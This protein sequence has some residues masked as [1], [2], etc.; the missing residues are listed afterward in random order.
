MSE[1]HQQ[2]LRKSRVHAHATS[3]AP[4]GMEPRLEQLSNSSPTAVQRQSQRQSNGSPIL[5]GF[6]DGSQK[7]RMYVQLYFSTPFSDHHKTPLKLDCRWTAVET[8][9]GLPLDCRWTAFVGGLGACWL[10]HVGCMQT[11]VCAHEWKIVAM[12]CATARHG[13]SAPKE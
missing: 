3:A 9:V 8:A 12:R 11:C 7:G 13:S 10:T 5:M 4:V 1:S 6:C 2:L